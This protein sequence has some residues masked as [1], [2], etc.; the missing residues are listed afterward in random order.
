MTKNRLI[1]WS[2]I[3]L[4]CIGLGVYYR[5]QIKAD[6]D[7]PLSSP[8]RLVLIVSGSDPYWE[9]VIAGANDAAKRYGA[10][11]AVHVPSDAEDQTSLISN[12]DAQALD[13]VAISPLMPKEQL[14]LLN[15][16]SS[17][18]KLVTLDNDHPGSMRHCYVG[19][20]NYAAGRTTAQ[21]LREALPEGG[22]VV[23]FTGDTE[24]LNGRL[25]RQGFF[26]E[27]TR[28]SRP[29]GDFLDPLDEL[30]EVDSF[31]IVK[32]YV[33]SFNR[34]RATD[35][36]KQALEEHPNAKAMVGF[37]AYHGPKCL[38]ALKEQGKLGAIRLIAFDDRK[39]TLQGVAEG[40][41]FAAIVQDTYHYGYE[42]IRLLCE[43][44]GGADYAVP[45][46]G[47]GNT[48]LPC[49]IIKKDDLEKY[50]QRREKYTSSVT[51][52]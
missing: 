16:T 37:Y 45:V 38:S 23:L 39:E 26:D 46:A 3:A 15:E 4:L 14:E 32:T 19:T 43:M 1:T 34:N 5:T 7:A 33:D 11:L 6:L 21:L 18:V 25:R 31:Q 30:V 52:D 10:E 36:V 50:L 40:D 28:K 29:P 27:L 20:D 35:N 9:S 42:A 2:A 48:Y 44:V 17:K 22:E 12:L 8:P 51:R 13:G 47:G 24:R 49:S 41:V